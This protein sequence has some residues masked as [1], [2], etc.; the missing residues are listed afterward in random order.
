MTALCRRI[1]FFGGAHNIHPALIISQKRRG[2]KQYVE[3]TFK[4]AEKAEMFAR[5]TPH[6]TFFS[7]FI[8]KCVL[9]SKLRYMLFNS[10]PLSHIERQHS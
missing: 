4:I 7:F 8:H 5:P 2:F 10:N 9:Q 6:I 1:L 3:M